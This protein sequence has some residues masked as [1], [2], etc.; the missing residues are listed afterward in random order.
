MRRRNLN[1]PK[2]A[3]RSAGCF[4]TPAVAGIFY[5]EKKEALAELLDHLLPAG[6]K[7]NA[8][9][10]VVPHGGY[11]SSGSVAAAV[12]GR[13]ELPP[14]AV[15]VGPNHS[16]LGE[17]LSIVPDG[18][19]ITPLGRVPV[20]REAARAILKAVPLLK[21]DL[22]AHQYEHSVEVQLPFL[23]RWGRVRSFVPIGIG[24]VDL[25]TAREIGRATA[26]AVRRLGKKVLWIASSDLSRYEPREKVESQDR[27]LIE[28]ILALDEEGLMEE[29]VRQSSS[30]C[31][32]PAVAVVL[33][34]AKALGA[35]QASL[36]KYEV[37]QIT[38]EDAVGV[39]VGYAGIL[40]K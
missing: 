28:P 34:A 20:D 1:S 15:I 36:V 2:P 17:R 39:A 38:M 29:A 12:Y 27:L 22:E 5:P 26:E 37:G 24:G 23:Q 10:A 6:K 40:V 11:F 18:E 30:M 9:A 3:D 35:S 4:R 31:G 25:E 19:W 21:K 16:G 7:E 33:A 14:T 8:V 13:V 32:A